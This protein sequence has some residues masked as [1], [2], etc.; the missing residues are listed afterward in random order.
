[1]GASDEGGWV[2]TVRSS[3]SAWSRDCCRRRVRRWTGC[4]RRLGS[5]LGRWSVGSTLFKAQV[6]PLSLLTKTP[7]GWRAL[8][9]VSTP[10]IRDWDPYRTLGDSGSRC[11][12]TPS[13]VKPVVILV[14]VLPPSVLFATSPLGGAVAVPARK[15][16]AYTVPFLGSTTTFP[17]ES[18]NTGCQVFPASALLSR[19]QGAVP[20]PG[21]QPEL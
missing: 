15:Q 21:P 16:P 10:T 19:P 5:A 8:L 14:K 9:L 6:A 17:Q 4:H 1:M 3:K 2:D 18:A 11:T 7:A 20:R 13:R 12:S